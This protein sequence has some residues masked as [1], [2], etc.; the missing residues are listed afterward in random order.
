M[1]REDPE[2]WWPFLEPAGRCTLLDDANGCALPYAERPRQC[3]DLVPGALLD[4][5]KPAA[6]K[7]AQPWPVFDTWRPHRELLARCIMAARGHRAAGAQQR[8]AGAGSLHYG[9]R[10]QRILARPAHAYRPQIADLGRRALVLLRKHEGAGADEEQL[11]LCPECHGRGG[12]HT[13]GCEWSAI[14]RALDALAD[15]ERTT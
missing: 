1:D 3:R 5:G 11:W 7:P 4:G 12:Q 9:A 2:S 8:G 15:P 10:L 6:C 14:L 13:P